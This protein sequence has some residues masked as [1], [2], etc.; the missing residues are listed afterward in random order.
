[1]PLSSIPS[2]SSCNQS[3]KSTSTNLLRCQGCKAVYYCGREHQLVDREAH[4]GVCNAIKKATKT[5]ASEEQRLRS[6]PADMFMPQ[7]IFEEHA[8]HFWGIHETRPYMRARYG[9]VE[10]LLKIKTYAAVKAAHEHLMEMLRLCRGD[11]MGVRDIVPALFL[12][13]GNDQGCYDF[14]VWYATTGQSGD[15]DWGDMD[16]GFL[17]VK[18]ANVFEAVPKNLASK[19][20]DLSHA[21]AITLLKIKVLMDVRS[22]RDSSIIGEKV[23]QEIID[24]IRTQ[25]VTGTVIARHVNVTDVDNQKSVIQTLEGQIKDLYTTIEARNVHFWPA[26]LSPGSN[27]IARPQAY[28]HG[29]KSEMQLVLKYNYEAWS[30]TPG[31]I[32]M[33]RDLKQGSGKF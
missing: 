9:V 10:A 23:P 31:A 29:S 13:L 18:D 7:P 26:L 19:Y 4:K 24:D 32:D 12:R 30:E 22:L 20:C 21:V 27:L 17:D 1:M 14:C 11:N 25:L 16:L 8:G 33:I 28:S 5:L 6:L 15:Y 3:G 2:C